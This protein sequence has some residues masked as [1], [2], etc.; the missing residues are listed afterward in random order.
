MLYCLHLIYRLAVTPK[1]ILDERTTLRWPYVVANP[2]VCRLSVGLVQRALNPNFMGVKSNR[3]VL[4]VYIH[5][6]SPYT[7]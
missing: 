5:L 6:Y 3:T 1:P 4:K 2:S 7:W